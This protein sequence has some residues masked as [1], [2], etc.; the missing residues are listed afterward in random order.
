M[1]FNLK[2]REQIMRLMTSECIPQLAACTCTTN[3]SPELRFL[4][5]KYA[6]AGLLE[7]FP[8]LTVMERACSAGM[9][10]RI[11]NSHS[12]TSSSWHMTTLQEC[13]VVCARTSIR[14]LYATLSIPHLPTPSSWTMSLDPRPHLSAAKTRRGGCL[15]V[16]LSMIWDGTGP[17]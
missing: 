17:A 15:F 11:G 4:V 14:M 3:I 6:T 16:I 9:P 8:G 12:E 7:A 2:A 5:P 13:K 10:V 1:G